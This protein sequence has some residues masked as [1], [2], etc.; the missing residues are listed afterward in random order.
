M[1][2]EKGDARSPLC[3]PALQRAAV[4]LGK[5]VGAF[6]TFVDGRAARPEIIYILVYRHGYSPHSATFTEC[7]SDGN[8][9]S[10]RPCRSV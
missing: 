4:A 9:L 10:R 2:I 1:E 8:A 3:T 5:A 6:S 7:I